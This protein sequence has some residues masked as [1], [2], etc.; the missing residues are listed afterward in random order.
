MIALEGG[1]GSG[2]STVLKLFEDKTKDSSSKDFSFKVFVFDCFK[3]QNGPIRRAFIEQFHSFLKDHVCKCKHKKLKNIVLKATG[4]IN[5]REGIEKFRLGFWTL[6]FAACLPI[7]AAS[8]IVWGNAT[9]FFGYSKNFLLIPTLIPVMQVIL[10]TLVRPLWPDTSLKTG[11]HTTRTVLLNTTE[12]TSIDLSK[13]YEEL[14]TLLPNKIKVIIVLDNI[15]RLDT[16][17]L[18]DV[19]ADMEVFSR[20]PKGESHWVIVPYAPKQLQRAFE[21]RYKHPHR[22]DEEREPASERE[23]ASYEPEDEE[24]GE[25]EKASARRKASMKSASAFQINSYN[26][27][28]EFINK[29]F[30]LRY[31]VP[32]ILL[33]DWKGYFSEKWKYVFPEAR[34][35]ECNQ[36]LPL[37]R[38]YRRDPQ[39]ITPRN[40]KHFINGVAVSWSST[41]ETDIDRLVVT[42]YLLL[43]DHFQGDLLELFTDRKEHARYAV[44][45]V[46][47]VDKDWQKSMASLHYNVLKERAQQIILAPLMKAA[48]EGE[49]EKDL[50]E[51]LELDGG[52]D[53]LEELF[54]E[55]PSFAFLENVFIRQ[56]GSKEQIGYKIAGLLKRKLSTVKPDI[57]QYPSEFIEAAEPILSEE[58]GQYMKRFYDTLNYQ[59][60]ETEDNDCKDV[61]SSIDHIISY[62]E[63]P[64]VITISPENLVTHWLHNREEYPNIDISR[65]QTDQDFGEACIIRLIQAWENAKSQPNLPWVPPDP[66]D[67]GLLFQQGT[68][69]SDSALLKDHMPTPNEW[70][71]QSMAEK[72]VVQELYLL[73]I[74]HSDNL[75][76]QHIFDTLLTNDGIESFDKDTKSKILTG[77]LALAIK[78]KKYSAYRRF[79]IK[80]NISAQSETIDALLRT[81]CGHSGVANAMVR[82]RSS[83]AEQWKNIIVSREPVDEF[84]VDFYGSGIF[85]LKPLQDAI[86]SIWEDRLQQGTDEL[87]GNPDF[88]FACTNLLHTDFRE[89]LIK[90]I[91]K[92]ILHNPTASSARMLNEL[93]QNCDDWPPL[94]MPA[95]KYDAR[96][97][98]KIIELIA[99]HPD[100]YPDLM[101]HVAKN[102]DQIAQKIRKVHYIQVSDIRHTLRKYKEKHDFDAMAHLKEIYEALGVN[103]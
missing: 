82:V 92:L 85:R 1:L 13:Y 81:S 49:L 67:L 25:E 11:K 52:Y 88:L 68:D 43:I 15:D 73:V 60:G 101:E 58:I 74:L 93:I 64:E 40:I 33:S 57:F 6:F 32:E 71:A 20:N 26:M 17:K 102:A 12:V 78:V 55:D 84:T 94:I 66:S 87:D 34:E 30:T 75:V 80:F 10:G 36:V 41:V 98:K 28:E 19:W 97:F 91:R 39:D 69:L 38:K 50:G 70:L 5:E 56:H 61:L 42:A 47:K 2:K 90:R 35:E 45:L 21:E 63:E 76:Y 99:K 18:F 48:I 54:E 62:I 16:E 7:S 103:V 37:F 83:D 24:D 89:S 86:V 65:F 95:D 23:E 46:E 53:C 31:R 27:T 51:L 9:E 14:L 77:L 59:L 96:G 79:F 8:L 22:K 72:T 3:Y 44:T 29:W 4:R 100:K